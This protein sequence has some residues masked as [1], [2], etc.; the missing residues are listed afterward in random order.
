MKEYEILVCYNR[1]CDI[2]RRYHKVIRVKAEDMKAACK[3]IDDYGVCDLFDDIEDD[4]IEDS[5]YHVKV[6]S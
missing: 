2:T 1:E 6:L 3:I 4:Y 5:L